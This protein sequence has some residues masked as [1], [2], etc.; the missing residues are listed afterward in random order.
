MSKVLIKVFVDVL[1]ALYS[2]SLEGNICGFDTNRFH[3]SQG[4]GGPELSTAVHAGD[5]VFW[6]PIALECEAPIA[7]KGIEF[8]SPGFSASFVDRMDFHIL[9]TTVP[10]FSTI[11]PYTLH[12]TFGNHGRTM[13]YPSGFTLRPA[14]DYRG[15]A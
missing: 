10:D 3:G 15:W 6:T 1:S 4:F 9:Q 14:E 5:Q 8:Q 12:F 13:Q 7:L 2:D 11:E